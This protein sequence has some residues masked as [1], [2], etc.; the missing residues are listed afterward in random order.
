[1]KQIKLD[2]ARVIVSQ[3]KIFFSIEKK[4][5]STYL[6]PW[7]FRNCVCQHWFLSI[8]LLIGATDLAI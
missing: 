2:K 8:V 7:M 3:D 6:G 1:M 4:K 5:V